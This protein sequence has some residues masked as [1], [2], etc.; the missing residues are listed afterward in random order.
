MRES[1]PLLRGALEVMILGA[2][3]GGAA[4]GPGISRWIRDTTGGV[5]EVPEGALYPALRRRGR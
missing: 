3:S 4:P 2:L 1:L 5:F